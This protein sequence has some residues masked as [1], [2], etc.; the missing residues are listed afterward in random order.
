MELA[1]NLALFG[2]VMTWITPLWVVALGAAGAVGLMYLIGLVLRLFAP[3]VQAIARTTAKESLA[4]PLFYVLLALG[5]FG[6]L[7]FPFIPYNTFGED[8]KMLKAEGLTLIKILAIIL[9]VWSASVSISDEIEG[10]TALTILSKPLGRRRLIVGK[11]LGVI[12]PV[13]ILFIVLGSLFLA[14]VSYKVVYDAR[15]N[16]SPAPSSAQCQ[17]EMGQIVPG[18]A[19]SFMEAVALASISVAISTRLPMLANLVICVSIYVL[20]H[21]VPVFVHST[22]GEFAIVGFVGNLLSAVLPVLDHFNM[23][24]AI[25]TGQ[26]VPAVY[27]VFAGLYCLVYCAVAMLLALLLFEERDV[28]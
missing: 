10:R 25:S 15:E 19:L 5:M 26:S 20:G 24:T 3:R 12:T 28:A 6:I 27:L 23:E 18:L 17:Q 16:A 7:V 21:L 11:F 14:S 1:G 4:Q 9:A 13:V 8:V 22:L 2:S